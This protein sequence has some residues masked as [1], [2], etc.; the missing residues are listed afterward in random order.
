MRTSY[1]IGK[2]VGKHIDWIE[3]Q[4]K[5]TRHHKRMFGAIAKC[6]TAALGGH[7]KACLDCAGVQIAYNSC[8]NRNCPKCQGRLREK[9]VAAREAD[10]IKVPYF[11][12]VFTLPSA[13]NP[14]CLKEPETMYSILFQAAWY[15]IRKLGK[16]PKWCGAK[17][18]MIALLHTWGS[19]LSLHPHLHCIVPAGGISKGEK[20]KSTRSQGKYLFNR[21]VMGLIFRA[22]FVALLRKSSVASEIHSHVYAQL[23]KKEW[24]VYAKQPFFDPKHIIAYLGRYS[25]KIAITNHRIVNIYEDKIDFKYKDYKQGGKQ[26]IMCLTQRQFLQ[27]FA[28]HIIPHKF[29]RIRHYGFLCSRFKGQYLAQIR[30]KAK[31]QATAPKEKMPYCPK[32]IHCQSTQLV[33]IAIIPAARGDPLK[34]AVYFTH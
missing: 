25:H 29:V 21:K 12:T 11:H 9:W 32:C 20:W 34:N 6:R 17:M 33:S 3:Q 5:F 24:I 23:F 19:N 30:K 2:L 28:M 14:I 8:R 22:R 1:D 31:F 27:R 16:D 26:K 18:G 15:T 7:I 13:L 4:D 10:L